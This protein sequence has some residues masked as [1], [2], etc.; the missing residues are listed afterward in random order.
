MTRPAYVENSTKATEGHRLRQHRSFYSMR[1]KPWLGGRA[2]LTVLYGKRKGSKS[3]LSCVGYE[4]QFFKKKKWTT[5]LWTPPFPS[6][7][8]CEELGWREEPTLTTKQTYD[9]GR[10]M[11]SLYR[12]QVEKLQRGRGSRSSSFAT[13]EPK[14]QDAPLDILLMQPSFSKSLCEPIRQVDDD[15]KR[16]QSNP[17]DDSASSEEECKVCLWTGII[18]CT[19]LSAYFAHAAFDPPLPHETLEQVLR[20]RRPLYLAISAGW[21]CLGAYRWHLG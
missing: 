8:A 10:R 5:A 16:I 20:Q 17:N 14:T 9:T 4:R 19:G 15:N 12:H 6:L 2:T 1:K 21:L 13:G 18:T 11:F 7:I 3:C